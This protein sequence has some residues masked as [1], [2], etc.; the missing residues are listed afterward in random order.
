VTATS[1]S[2]TLT[3]LSRLSKSIYRKTPES[4]L[5]MNARHYLAMSYIVDA[6]WVSQQQLSEILCI[7]A[8]NTVLLLNEMEKEGLIVRVRDPDDR[9]RHR[10]QPT[11]LGHAVFRHAQHARESVEDEVLTRLSRDERTTLH[12]LLAKALGE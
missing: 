5:G 1:T 6:S 11:E 9:R 3:L 12:D 10:V 4:L 7:D 2:G 8:N